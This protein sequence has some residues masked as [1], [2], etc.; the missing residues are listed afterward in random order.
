M[1]TVDLRGPE[2]RVDRS[3]PSDR[4]QRNAPD[5]VVRRMR[6]AALLAAGLLLVPIP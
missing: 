5:P 2:A 1:S 4:V 3:D 6:T